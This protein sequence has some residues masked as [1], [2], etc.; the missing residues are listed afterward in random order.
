MRFIALF[1]PVLLVSCFVQRMEVQELQVRQAP[2]LT[3]TQIL[4]G[5]RDIQFHRRFPA[6]NR[7]CMSC[8]GGVVR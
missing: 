6:A 1:I 5:E 8:H 2:V 3:E 4:A 7:N